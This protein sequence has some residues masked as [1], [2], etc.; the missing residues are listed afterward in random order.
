MVRKTADYLEFT[1]AY[2]DWRLSHIV[3]SDVLEHQKHHE[4]AHNPLISIIVPVYK[5]PA[6]FLRQMI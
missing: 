4:F 1:K 3:P 5:T 2:N 6:R